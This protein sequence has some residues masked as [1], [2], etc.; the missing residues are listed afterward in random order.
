MNLTDLPSTSVLQ[1][2]Y[3]LESFFAN[4]SNH[5]SFGAHVLNGESYVG[6]VLAARFRVYVADVLASQCVSVLSMSH[7]ASLCER[8]RLPTI[9]CTLGHPVLL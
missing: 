9:S 1:Y 8:R 7:Y 5:Y 3:V 6:G 4:S 2:P